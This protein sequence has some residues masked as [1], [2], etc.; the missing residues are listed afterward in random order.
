[1]RTLSAATTSLDVFLWPL[2]I[3]VVLWIKR[4]QLRIGREIRLSLWLIL[5]AFLA[6]PEVMMTGAYVAS[7]LVIAVWLV[8]LAAGSPDEGAPARSPWLTL[9][10]ATFIV[11]RS[12]ILSIHWHSYDRLTGEVTAAFDRLPKDALVFSASTQ[13]FGPGHLGDK[14]AM[15]PPIW[16]WT[17]LAVLHKQ[18][19]VPEMHA[20]PGQQPLTV[21][22]RFAD[23]YAFHDTN[24]IAIDSGQPDREASLP[25]KV[26][27]WLGIP[28]DRPPSLK[29]VLKEIGDLA[30]AAGIPPSRTFLLVLDPEALSEGALPGGQVR[31]KGA[32]FSLI[33]VLPAEIGDDLHQR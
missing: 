18:A 12:V 6:L 8:L 29:S 21:S 13:R 3:L 1:L 31:A 22:G 5:L 24:P 15:Q 4:G 9:A 30:E 7:R 20:N 28:L 11:Y 32:R 16:H 33:Q 19:F 10:I 27:D 26:F 2:V 17:D 23:I 14:S 25:E